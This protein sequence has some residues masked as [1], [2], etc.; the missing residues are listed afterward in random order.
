MTDRE[1][2]T[3]PDNERPT[4]PSPPPS[5]R[6]L[7]REAPTDPAPPC[8]HEDHEHLFGSTYYCFS[9]MDRFQGPSLDDL[10]NPTDPA[11][12]PLPTDA[13]DPW[14]TSGPFMR[15]ERE[16]AVNRAMDAHDRALYGV[17]FTDSGDPEGGTPPDVS[18]PNRVA[19]D[20]GEP[21]AFS[22]RFDPES[23]AVV[24][25]PRVPTRPWYD[26]GKDTGPRLR[27][28]GW[29]D[30]PKPEPMPDHDGWRERHARIARAKLEGDT[31]VLS[32]AYE[33]YLDELHTTSTPQPTVSPLDWDELEPALVAELREWGRAHDVPSGSI[34]LQRFF[35]ASCAVRL[36]MRD[37][38]FE[39][40][41]D[42][43]SVKAAWRDAGGAARRAAAI[44]VRRGTDELAQARVRETITIPDPTM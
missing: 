20:G 28:K 26:Y 44:L 24:P 23:G 22:Y 1:S 36:V 35:D 3:L 30:P 8:R 14:P 39:M 32:K 25:G 17:R 40:R 15:T 21:G 27:V 19:P 37:G 38:T 9:C 16:L 18:A 10:G 7:S 12:P 4:D 5:S 11:P 42:R 13:P 43:R 31:T 29:A 6:D 41:C 2:P 34:G 33:P